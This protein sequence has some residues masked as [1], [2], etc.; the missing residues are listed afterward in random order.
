MVVTRLRHEA[1]VDHPL[2]D[3]L[4]G[5]RALTLWL[6][7]DCCDVVTEASEVVDGQVEHEIGRHIPPLS[8]VSTAG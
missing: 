2:H 4:L 7:W 3:E 6:G 8:V 5:G 1:A